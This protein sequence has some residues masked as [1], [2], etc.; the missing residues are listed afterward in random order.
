MDQNQNVKCLSIT[1]ILLLLEVDPKEKG[2]LPQTHQKLKTKD[3]LGIDID[4]FLQIN[5]KKRSL[6]SKGRDT[7]CK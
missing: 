6:Q 7:S 2:S 3:F 1:K 5:I 4:D